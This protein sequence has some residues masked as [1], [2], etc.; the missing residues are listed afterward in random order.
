MMARFA[1]PVC[2]HNVIVG[3]SYISLKIILDELIRVIEMENESGV[4]KKGVHVMH[5]PI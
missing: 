4:H 3:Y 1:A 2:L 5:S